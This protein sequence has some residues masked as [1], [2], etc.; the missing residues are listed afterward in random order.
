METK[1]KILIADEN[2]DFRK[3]CKNGLNTYGYK[4]IE[5]AV[6]EKLEREGY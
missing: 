2:A 5:E 1:I 6:R 4:Y 3:N